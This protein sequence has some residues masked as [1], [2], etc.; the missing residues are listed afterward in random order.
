M[1]EMDPFM[2]VTMKKTRRELVGARLTRNERA[3]RTREQILV[4]TAHVVGEFGYRDSSIQ[5]ITSDAGI[6]QGTFYLY[7]ESRQALFDELLPH[8][9]VQML[10]RVRERAHG[11]KGFFDVEEIGVRAVFEYLYEN[12]WFWRVLNEAEIEAPAAWAQ[13][14]NEVTSRY[15]KFLKRARADGEISTYGESELGTLAYLLIAARDY[16]YVYHLNRPKRSEGIPESVIK[17]YMHFL[18]HGLGPSA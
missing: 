15:M 5:R 9:G 2:Q 1:K 13:H 18:K 17:T 11:A 12:P 4:S 8:F 7:F 3:A 16:L 6:A 10:E 14:H